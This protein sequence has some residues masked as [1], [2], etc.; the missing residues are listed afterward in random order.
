M[1]KINQVN[2]KEFLAEQNLSEKLGLN[3]LEAHKVIEKALLAIGGL[4]KRISEMKAFQALSGFKTQELQIFEDKLSFILNRISPDSKMEQFD[5]VIEITGMPSFDDIGTDI[6]LNLDKFLKVR[7][8]NDC[9]EFRNWLSE[10][11]NLEDKEIK[12]G[13]ES[14]R[15]MIG[16]AIEGKVGKSIRF[17][18]STLFGFLDGGAVT[19]PA[20]GAIDTFVLDKVF[21]SKGPI[22]FLN[23]KY[24]SIYS[25]L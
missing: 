25:K 4:N 3:E 12:E 18:T 23:K 15:N 11:S 16:S 9:V 2:E 6:K 1:V 24:P 19:G 20:I 8:S 7:E 21:P 10:I 17:L 14:F 22:T 13:I 5:R